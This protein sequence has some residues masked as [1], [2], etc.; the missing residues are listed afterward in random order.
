M[1]RAIRAVKWCLFL[2]SLVWAAYVVHVGSA[3]YGLILGLEAFNRRNGVKVPPLD[4]LTL[5][6]EIVVEAAIPLLAAG[7]FLLVKW[8]EKSLYKAARGSD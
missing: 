6:A 3:I 8:P 2:L 7:I 5:L 4:N 1:W